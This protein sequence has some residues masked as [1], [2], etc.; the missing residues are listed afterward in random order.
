MWFTRDLIVSSIH[1]QIPKFRLY[2]ILLQQGHERYHACKHRGCDCSAVCVL[3]LFLQP[4]S[5]GTLSPVRQ[6]ST[7]FW[8]WFVVPPLYFWCIE[9]HYVGTHIH[10]STLLAHVPLKSSV[11]DH[12]MSID[13][14][15]L[16][17]NLCL[18]SQAPPSSKGAFTRQRRRHQ[19]K[20]FE[21][22]HV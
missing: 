15:R 19:R 14:K 18:D 9:P 20:L 3:R 2:A 6:C 13:S 7:S 21:N 22:C 1:A 16:Q 10:L 11:H 4:V 12:V 8:K 17:L 5:Y